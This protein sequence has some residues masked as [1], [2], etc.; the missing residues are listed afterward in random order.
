MLIFCR[1]F[2]ASTM[3]QVANNTSTV[4]EHYQYALE[5]EITKA[6]NFNLELSSADESLKMLTLHDIS[7]NDKV[8][9][10]YNVTEALKREVN[11]YESIFIFTK[12]YHVS[13]FACGLDNSNGAYSHIY[14]LKDHLRDYWID[15]NDAAYGSWSLFQDDKYTVLMTARK[16]KDIYICST[17]DLNAFAPFSY[18]DLDFG[19]FDKSAILTNRQSLDQFALDRS[20]LEKKEAASLFNNYYLK[21]ADI[22][23]TSIGMFGLY[24]TPDMW[25]ITRTSVILAIVLSLVAILLLTHFINKIVLYPLNKINSAADKLD[26]NNMDY[27][28]DDDENILE[29]RNINQALKNLISKTIELEDKK[30]AEAAQKDHAQLQYLQLQTGSHFFI[31]CLK[32]LYSM[33]SNKQYENMERMIFAFS[34]HLRY[35][36]R[37]NLNLVSLGE[38]VNEVRDYYNIVQMD[39]TN[40][41]ILDVQIDESLM[42]IA[43]PPLMIQTFLENTVKYNRQ[44]ENLLI[45][46]VEAETTEIDGCKMLQLRISDNGIGYNND[47][48]ELLN[49]DKQ[50]LYSHKQVGIANLKYRISIIYHM[51]PKTFT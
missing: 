22:A 48:L 29:Y 3:K 51:M 6:Q 34:N 46:K 41:F 27:L 30:N 32:S 11:S 35:V 13:T 38:E 10:L 4:L 37:N 43:V 24:H 39:L 5:Q 26:Q 28:L 25:T 33:L 17:I 12:D 1:L 45:F 2:I 44:T 9:Y 14:Q 36:F 7:G 19:F 8:H 40:P 31:N 47:I 16:L 15:N 18:D 42:H 21:T 50:S 23:N 49:S 20:D